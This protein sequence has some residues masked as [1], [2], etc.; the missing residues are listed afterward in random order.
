MRIKKLA[1]IWLVVAL[2]LTGCAMFGA[3]ATPQ[4]RYDEALASWNSIMREFRMQYAMQSPQVQDQW[5]K[6]FAIPLYEAG[7]ALGAWGNMIDDFTKEQAFI[8]LK[9]HAIRLLFQYNIIEIKE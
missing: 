6:I 2:L 9:N 8:T 5:D 3:N 1:A 4:D 7:V